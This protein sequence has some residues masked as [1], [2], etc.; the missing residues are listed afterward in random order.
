[1]AVKLSRVLIVERAPENSVPIIAGSAEPKIGL[2]KT[3]RIRYIER[4]QGSPFD[5]NK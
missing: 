3:K 1:M 5:L 4:C 2:E